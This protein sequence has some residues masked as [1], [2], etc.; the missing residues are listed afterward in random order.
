MA[1]IVSRT[2][3]FSDGTIAYGSQVEQE[4]S[5]LYTT[6]NN[7]NNA[8][9]NWGR[10][11][12]LNTT[13]VPLI[14]DCSS[15][16]QNIA[17]FNNN[18]VVKASVGSDGTITTV[19][20]SNQLVL[21][22][23]NTTTIS[24]TA[25]SASRTVTIPDPGTNANFVMSE[26]NQ[27]INAVK[28]FAGGAGAITMSSSTIAMG[29]NKITGLANGTATTDG[30]TFGQIKLVQYQSNSTTSSTSTTSLTFV[31]ATNF[32]VTIT[33][34]SSSNKIF[35]ITS[36]MG[37]CASTTVG[38]NSYF[39]IV[40][41]TTNLGT[42][43]GFCYITN[44]SSATDTEVPVTI[45]YLDAPATTSSTTYKIQLRSNNADNTAW[46]QRDS[47]TATITV[48]ELAT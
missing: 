5:T 40:R 23:T 3:T 34:T 32:N 15:G 20:T 17:N 27:T 35:I 7:L 22:T 10:V 16:G 24:A 31:D 11:S 41:G 2:Y 18:S 44:V 4:F 30:A 21:G 6:L 1:N 39:T 28:T 36:F 13:S 9:T 43:D 38:R 42:T 47:Q 8:T 14:A 29:S 45:T 19:K 33:P 26:S 12:V 37:S 48:F 46:V 25:P